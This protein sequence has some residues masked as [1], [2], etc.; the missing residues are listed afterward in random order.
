[1]LTN[2]FCQLNQKELIAYNAKFKIESKEINNYFED[3]EKWI[4]SIAQVFMS[5]SEHI[6]YHPTYKENSRIVYGIY[7]NYMFKNI[8]FDTNYV[9]K[10]LDEDLFSVHK[11][12]LN[13]I[14]YC[15]TGE[16]RYIDLALPDF[17]GLMHHFFEAS[18]EKF[19]VIFMKFFVKG[20]SDSL[21]GIRNSLTAEFINNNYGRILRTLAFQRVD[22]TT[23]EFYIDHMKYFLRSNRGNHRWN[24]IDIV[25]IYIECQ[26]DPN[27]IDLCKYIIEFLIKNKHYKTLSEIVN[28]KNYTSDLIEV[29]LSRR[30]IDIE[31]ENKIIKQFKLK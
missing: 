13:F 10:K 19:K 18:D 15:K 23:I 11:S 30:L 24:K 7:F 29:Y 26:A 31:E 12:I 16:S 20:Y 5:D 21:L 27:S 14:M 4:E 22:H 9:L 6:K 2:A 25:N 17:P 3:P 28:N 8:D 1:M